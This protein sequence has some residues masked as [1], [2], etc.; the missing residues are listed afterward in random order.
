MKPMLDRCLAFLHLFGCSLLVFIPSKWSDSTVVH[1]TSMQTVA[2]LDDRLFSSFVKFTRFKSEYDH[3]H[4]LYKMWSNGLEIFLRHHSRRLTS[5]PLHH[6]FYCLI[7]ASVLIYWKSRS[8]HESHSTLAY[9]GTLPGIWGPGRPG[10]HQRAEKS[11]YCKTY[12]NDIQ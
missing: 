11:K 10:S 8:N 12:I 2:I 1:F 7:S 3:H 4:Y 5:G 9:L 6:W